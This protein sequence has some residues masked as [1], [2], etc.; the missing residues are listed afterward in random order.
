MVYSIGS[1]VKKIQEERLL[2]IVDQLTT[3]SAAPK[4]EQL[5]DIANLGLRTVIR[6]ISPTSTFGATTCNKLTPK[7]IDQLN[8]KDASQDGLLNSAELMNDV[9]LRFDT[10]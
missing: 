4:D 1:L 10:M 5:R 8:N 7:L 3:Y 9:F 6:E 2:T